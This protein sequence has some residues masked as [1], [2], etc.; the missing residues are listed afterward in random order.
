MIFFNKFVEVLYKVS[1]I[2]KKCADF[3]V[4]SQILKKKKRRSIL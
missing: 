4:V 3:S 1:I 2:L